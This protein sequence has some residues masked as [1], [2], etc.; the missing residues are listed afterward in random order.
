MRSQSLLARVVPLAAAALLTAACDGGGGISNPPRL[1]PADVQGVYSFCSLKFVPAQTALP[2]AN[3]L[4]SIVALNPPAPKQPPSL[5]LSGQSAS[6]QLLYTRKTDSFTQD[7]RGTVALGVDEIILSVPDEATTEVRRELL[8]PA[9]LLL[10]FGRSPNQ[11][12][13]TGDILYSVRRADYAHAAGIS[14]EGLQDRINGS[15]TGLLT[16]GACP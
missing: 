2:Q 14:E 4:A 9:Q 15:L 6:Y 7:L 5:T 8:L 13:V 3:L 16:T 12:A 1:T 10:H 11:L